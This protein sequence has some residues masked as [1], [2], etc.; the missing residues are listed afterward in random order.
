VT[1]PIS[2]AHGDA[3]PVQ[4]LFKNVAYLSA[5]YSVPFLLQ[6]VAGILIIPITTRFLTPSDFAIIDLVDQTLGV[7]SLLLGIRF[8]AALG[9]FYFQV[10]SPRDRKRIAA[11]A[12]L[13]AGLIGTLAAGACWPFST[14]LSRAVFGNPSAA[15]YFHIS[16]LTWT[17]GFA[18]E[19]LFAL[20]RVENRIGMYNAISAFRL[21]TGIATILILVAVLKLRVAGMLYAALLAGGLTMILML[22]DLFR[23][24]PPAFDSRVFISM[25][26]YALP[27][28]F[29]G[30]A[31]FIINVG[32]R[33]FL[34]HYRPLADVGIYVL[35]YKIGMLI[36]FIYGS[37]EAYWS[38]Q[39]FQLMRRNDSDWVFAR[40]FTYVVLGIFFCVLILAV[41]ARPV[42]RIM[43][44][45]AFLGAA[46][47]VPIIALA[48]CI[49]AIGS[50]LCSI[51][52]VAGKPGYD[53]IT[54]WLGSLVCLVSYWIL[55]PRFGY[56]GAAYATLIAF[57]VIT[58][59]S[60]VWTYRLRP[61]RVE[62]GR[63]AKIGA[64]LAL[65]ALPSLLLPASSLMSQ[66]GVAV[67]SSAIFPCALWAFRFATP[68]ELEKLHHGCSAAQVVILRLCGASRRSPAGI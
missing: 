2:S 29:G 49:R 14:T 58:A 1:Q 50:F 9:Y 24:I 66:I 39:V 17:F 18:M 40:M 63:L 3:L 11:T 30:I 25:A 48:Y 60:A 26:K 31:T 16:L 42:L 27:L 68:G 22:A 35:A 13:G 67:A 54:N 15:P 37:F 45:P 53:A 20:M 19:A 6:R 10:E 47:L 55:I 36:A 33:F 7:V 32:D 51:F 5:A 23:R 4:S 62:A 21:V 41:C 28:G 57:G 34:P 59:I 64:S 43:V 52:L 12:I 65:A 44:A 61:Y 38:A 46:P 56:W 8:A